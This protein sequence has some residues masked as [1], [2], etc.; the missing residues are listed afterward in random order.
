MKPARF[1]TFGCRLNTYETEVMRDLAGDAGLTETVVVNTCAVTNEAVRQARQQIRRARRD[2][3]DAQVIVTGCAAQAETAAFAQMPEV[4]AVIGNREK[5]RAET[6]T[7]LADQSTTRI[8]VGDIMSERKAVAPFVEGLGNRVRAYV[9][10]QTGCDHRCTFC[11]IPFGRGNSRSVPMSHVIEQARKLRDNGFNEIVLT[12][13]DIT[14]WGADLADETRLGTLV[15]AVLRHVPDLPRLRLS[16]IDS[17]E[18]DPLLMELIGG[19][20]RLMPHLH[21]S[22]Q[23]GDNLILK[24]MKRRHQ[25]EDAIAFCQEIRRVRSNVVFGA[26]LIAGFPTESDEMFES[27]L[28]LVDE[29]DLTWLHV[30]PFSPKNGTPAARMPQTPGDVIRERAARLRAKGQAR[31]DSKLDGL[32]GTRVDLLLERP[33][34]GRTEGFALTEIAGNYTPGEIVTAVITGRNGDR[35]LAASV[36]S[37]A[38]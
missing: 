20:P 5:L 11:I 21:L 22:L 3:P 34:L 36:Q 16:S 26:D 18:T 8:A 37:K 7:K 15:E 1:H 4:D 6:W 31:R 19:E 24:R 29:C 25:R 33:D 13:V 9:Q 30:F 38:A 10:I 27:S 35:L 28:A 23:H 2:A 14:S 12:G 17:V 32:R